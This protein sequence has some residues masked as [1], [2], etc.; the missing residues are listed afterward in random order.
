MEEKEYLNKEYEEMTEE[1][2][3]ADEQ[4]PEGQEEGTKKQKVSLLR[5]LLSIVEIFVAAFI[6][7]QFV[8]H[9]VLINAEVPSES[10]QNIIEPGDRLFGFR[11]AYTFGDPDR[12]DVVI[13]RYPVDESQNF[14]KRIIGLPGEKVEIREGKIYIDDSDTPL[15]EPY[16]PEEWDED[17]DGYVFEVLLPTRTWHPVKYCGYL[18]AQG[19]CPKA[20]KEGL[21]DNEQEAEKYTYVDSDQILGRAVFKYYPHFKSLLSY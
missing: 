21:A 19:S 1:T 10:M 15:D 8:V 14:I 17:N 5:E 12:F 20:L 11:L 16:L 2:E 4:A 18:P 3:P 13:F 7:A 6:L 9:F